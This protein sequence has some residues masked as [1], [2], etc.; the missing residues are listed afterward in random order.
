MI[1]VMEAV[2]AI[3][4]TIKVGRLRGSVYYRNYLLP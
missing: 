4:S 2:D 1:R 3:I